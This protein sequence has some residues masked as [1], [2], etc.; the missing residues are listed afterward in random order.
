MIKHFNT[1]YIGSFFEFC[2]I[3]YG[4]Y[5]LL[6]NLV[7]YL[8]IS[9]LKLNTYLLLIEYKNSEYIYCK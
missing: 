8:W 7:T 2:S 9:L 3:N 6:W 1:W 5:K 4:T